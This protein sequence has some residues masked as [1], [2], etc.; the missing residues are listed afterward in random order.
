MAYGRTSQ[1]ILNYKLQYYEETSKFIGL[2][3]TPLVSQYPLVISKIIVSET[4]LPQMI[5]TCNLYVQ[6]FLS[7]VACLSPI[8]V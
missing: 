4:C 8:A 1:S 3:N 6:N 5:F 7:D 2:P